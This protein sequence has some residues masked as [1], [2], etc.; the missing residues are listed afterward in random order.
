[1]EDKQKRILFLVLCT[2]FLGYTFTLYQQSESIKTVEGVSADLGKKVWQEKN[3][4]ACHQIYGLGGYLG[5]D[6]TNVYSAKGPNHIKAFLRSGTNIMPNFQLN[7][8][9]IENLTSYLKTIDKSGIGNPRKLK[10]N[11]DGTIQ[12]P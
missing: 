7:E 11:Y 6:L 3:C 8:T 12:Q 2:A 4:I 1:M 10:I 5:T 9:E